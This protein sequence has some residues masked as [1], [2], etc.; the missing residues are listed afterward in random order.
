MRQFYITNRVFRLL[1]ELMETKS[2]HSLVAI[3][4]PQVNLVRA[5]EYNLCM[6]IWAFQKRISQRL[7]IWSGF[8]IFIGIFLLFLK[9]PFWMGVASQ[10]I[11]WGVVDALVAAFGQS[12]AKKR[13]AKHSD[14]NP[15]L[16]DENEILT[17]RR[18]LQI[19]AVLDIFYIAAGLWLVLARPEILLKGVG[20]G[21]LV[22]GV[23]LAAFDLTHVF[24]TPKK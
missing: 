17:L 16:I 18:T 5:L 23:F 15:H 10:A 14:R 19:N 9:T 8:S 7:F 2:V 20:W 22:Q 24:L 6:D 3:F 12:G 1:P 4:I 21:V 13:K 11:V